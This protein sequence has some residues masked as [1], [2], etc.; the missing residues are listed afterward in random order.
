MLAGLFLLIAYVFSPLWD[1]DNPGYFKCSSGIE[2]KP[3]LKQMSNFQ[4]KKDFETIDIIQELNNNCKDLGIQLEVPEGEI[5]SIWRNNNI[6]VR[7]KCTDTISYWLTGGGKMPAT[8]KT[9]I[10]GLRQTKLHDLAN[11]IEEQM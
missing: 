3:S 10:E 6:E 9:F 4:F 5:S 11:R 7:S 2:C 1:P 8:W